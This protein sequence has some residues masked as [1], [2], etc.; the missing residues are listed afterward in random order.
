M[1]GVRTCRILFVDDEQSIL[2]GLANS[3]RRHRRTWDM[4]FANGGRD[5]IAQLQSGSFDL[6]VSDMRM[7]GM[8][9]AELMAWAKRHHPGAIRF[10]LSGQSASDSAERVMPLV[11]QYLSKPCDTAQL[12]GI[13]ERTWRFAGVITD[14]RI[15]D[16]IGR[17][18]ALPTDRPT[19]DGVV[20]ALTPL[21]GDTRVAS[22]R[23]AHSVALSA[24]A[25]QLANSD[26]FGSG[27]PIT[28]IAQAVQMIG[29]PRLSARV[30]SMTV[31]DEQGTDAPGGLPAD[32]FG[33][34]A[35]VRATL[36]ERFCA[37]PAM[38]DAAYSAALLLRVGRAVLVRASHPRYV[39]AVRLKERERCRL[40]EAERQLFGVDN[41]SVGAHLLGMWGLPA[42]IVGAVAAQDGCD[43]RPDHRELAAIVHAA[44]VFSHTGA[45]AAGC[46]ESML[47]RGRVERAGL[48]DRIPE[49]QRITAGA[50]AGLGTD[51]SL[52]EAR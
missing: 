15:R 41:A 18:D 22:Q 46:D 13:L 40:F 38:R 6:I 24:M 48:A 1:T 49:W 47:D 20:D 9:G 19:L 12:V 44:D 28:S 37:D 26:Y 25:L 43:E 3:L 14:C 36:A 29:A 11:H 31:D 45:E 42:T 4:V 30:A 27:S 10:V 2:D 34:R 32:Y 8:D 52:E 35:V 7:P 50:L 5:A 16:A 33:R 51:L 23:V 17:L 39:E 21:P